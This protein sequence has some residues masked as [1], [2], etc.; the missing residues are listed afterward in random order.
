MLALIVSLALCRQC[1]GN[2]EGYSNLENSQQMIGGSTKNSGELVNAN[3]QNTEDSF[4]KLLEVVEV[5]CVASSIYFD[6]CL[7]LE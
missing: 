3:L 2:T 1:V 6:L 5:K 7:I 4:E